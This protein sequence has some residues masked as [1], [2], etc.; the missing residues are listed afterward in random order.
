MTGDFVTATPNTETVKLLEN[1]FKQF[2]PTEK[3]LAVLGNHDHWSN[4][5]LIREILDRSNVIDISNFL[6]TIEREDAR[7]AIAGVDD[8]W[9]NQSDL[10]SVLQQLQPLDNVPAI[11]LAHEPDFADISAATHRFALQISGHSHGGQVKVPFRKPPVLPPY[12]QKY[13][14]GRYQ[15][16]DLIQYTNRGVGMVLPAVRLNCRPEIT[17]FTLNSQV[18]T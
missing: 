5:D 6:Y 15:V 4:P 8:Y 14:V 18:K 10:N 3:T 7:L 2:S 16:E 12:A 13:P 11:L 9:T 17:V 1:I